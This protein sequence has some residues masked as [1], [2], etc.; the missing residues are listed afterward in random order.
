MRNS[1]LAAALLVLF[2]GGGS[3]WAADPAAATY[4][5]TGFYAG[6]NT[7]FAKD[8]G[9]YSIDPASAVL[10]TGDFTDLAFIFGGQAGYNF[11]CCC[12]PYFVY[13]IEADISYDGM[14]DSITQ[15]FGLPVAGAPGAN[16][17]TSYTVTQEIDFFGTLRGRLG[18]TPADRLLFYITGGLAY[19]EVSSSTSYS[20]RFPGTGAPAF[21]GFAFSG[22]SSGMLVGWCAGAG[23][24]YALNNCWSVKLEYLYVDL[25][26]MSY[27][28]TG[29]DLTTNIST[30]QNVFRVGLNYKF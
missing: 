27:P 30:A 6:L 1:V 29:T 9:G 4:N 22:S 2:L 28:I 25:G 8:A 26:S 14:G 15:N 3:V 13:G 5:W 24:E 12:C 7:G 16:F 11:Q 23:G 20:V 21:P 19:G 10:D 18:Y 17:G